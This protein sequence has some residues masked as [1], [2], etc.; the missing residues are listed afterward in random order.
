MRPVA[1]LASAIELI[2]LIETEIAQSGVPMDRVIQGYFRT[3]RY[4]GSKDRRAISDMVYALY[5]MRER[6][7]WA[8]SRFEYPAI[9]GRSLFILWMQDTGLS[10]EEFSNDDQF[11]P[12]VLNDD[13]TGLIERY[14]KLDE[15]DIPELIVANVPE[16]AHEYFKARF[17]GNSISAARALCEKAPFSIRVNPIKLNLKSS[18]IS[19]KEISEGFEKTQYSPFGYSIAGSLNIS[20]NPLYK[21]GKI[22]IQDEA[23]QIASVLVD[24]K[25]KQTVVDLCAGAGGKSLCVGGLMENKG[26]IHAFDI[27]S[28]RLDELKKRSK[29]AGLHNIQTFKLSGDEAA[30]RDELAFLEA[31]AGRVILDVPCSGSGTWRRSPDLRWRYSNDNIM[32][33]TKVQTMLLREGAGLV[34]VGGRLIYMTCSLFQPENEDIVEGF[35]KENSDNWRAVPYDQIWEATNL[36]GPPVKTQ[37]KIPEFLQLSPHSHGTDGFFIAV[38]ERL[39]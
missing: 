11:A 6:L 4:A 17:E 22:E 39:A 10:F 9:N 7:I 35:L 33:I 16:Y 13:E 31:K 8:L 20:Q 28:K 37:S 12:D 2:D 1:R 23:A 5:R 26:Q 15:A 3:R 27:G 14:Q 19:I 29:R 36:I 18:D 34:K 32:E 38:L 24:A 21:S 30:R 25:P